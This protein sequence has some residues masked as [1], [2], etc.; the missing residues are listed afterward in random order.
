MIYLIIPILFSTF[1]VVIVNC[2]VRVFLAF[3]LPMYILKRFILDVLYNNRRS[4]T[5]N[6]IY[7]TILAPVLS[8]QILLELIGVKKT[9]FEVSPKNKNKNIV[10]NKKDQMMLLA[11]HS[12]LL[13]INIFGLVT[14]I[15]QIVNVD[16]NLY[17]ISLIWLISNIFYLVVAIIFDIGKKEKI[18]ESFGVSAICECTLKNDSNELKVSTKRISDNKILIVSDNKLKVNDKFKGYIFEKEYKTEFTCLIKEEIKNKQ[19]HEYVMEIVDIDRENKLSLYQVM[20]NRKPPKVD[21]FQKR[22]LLDIF[23]KYNMRGE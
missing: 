20:Y 3:W 13:I 15:K 14:C 17:Y 21:Y 1:G 8:V 11:A 12:L 7:E 2:D 22:A 9:I 18:L 6:K 19:V 23:L 4:A 5:W 10:K 16:I